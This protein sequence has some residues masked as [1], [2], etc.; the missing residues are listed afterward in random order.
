M[1]KP[2]NQS[3]LVF[4]SDQS[5]S[6]PDSVA[7]HL[8]RTTFIIDTHNPFF[9]FFNNLRRN[10]RLRH[11]HATTPID[12]II[13][14]HPKFVSEQLRAFAK[15]YHLPI[16]ANN[17]NNAFASD[18]IT[19]SKYAGFLVSSI[20]AAYDQASTPI[21]THSAVVPLFL[22]HSRYWNLASYKSRILS[23]AVIALHP[24]PN[25]LDQLM[26]A[27]DVVKSVEPELTIDV[28]TTNDQNPEPLTKRL[29]K[30]HLLINVAQ[31]PAWT[32]TTAM[33]IAAGIP[34]ITSYRP[35]HHYIHPKFLPGY[36]VKHWQTDNLIPII[37][38]S[39]AHPE[40]TYRIA[41][42][43]QHWLKTN[44]GSTFLPLTWVNGLNQLLSPVPETTQL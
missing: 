20:F 25:Q 3:H 14:D 30:A 27:L 13:V 43:A 6:L 10:W 17:L 29:R 33:T 12:A 18:I 40:E 35:L 38:N 26:S 42:N 8:G 21:D 11:L 9:Q 15:R 32:E 34:M 36:I 7:V 24:H 39:I 28:I 37:Q 19:K 22:S 4:L 31:D 16:I 23:L 1:T 5:F 41:K 44:L 2:L